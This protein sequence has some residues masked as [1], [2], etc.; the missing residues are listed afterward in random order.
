MYFTELPQLIDLRGKTK[1]NGKYSDL[2]VGSKT[3]IAIHHSLTTQGSSAAFANFHVGTN[4]WPGVAYHF[5]ILKDGTIE[6]NHNLGVKSYHVGNSNRFAVGICLVGD[7]R[8]EE[9]TAEQKASLYVLVDALK[10]DLPNYKRTRG[11]NEFPD[12]AWKHC[13]EF[14][15]RAVCSKSVEVAKVP[16]VKVPSEY[17]IQEGD[18]LWSVANELKG[19][20]VND[21][22]AANPSINP[23]AIRIGQ[24]INLTE[25]KTAVKSAVKPVVKAPVKSVS[26]V[27]SG[28]LR[29]GDR[30][31]AVKALQNVL[32]SVNFK[33]GT[34][35]GVF[36]ANTENALK[37]FQ[38]MY[39][40]LSV[41]GVYGPKTAAKLKEALK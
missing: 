3:D 7:F 39:Y 24:R 35:D 2:G 14:D 38:S 15:Y 12:Y 27:P 8:T 32:N 5:V 28:V 36:G 34:A 16:A 10:R 11:H 4:K 17:V 6:W 23:S 25:P 37:R 21:L 18:T 26:T 29:K 20:T 9:P 30:G 40:G 41:D 19:V 1:S 22:I 31:S 33:C 13:P